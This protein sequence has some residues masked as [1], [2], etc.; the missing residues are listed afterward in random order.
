VIVPS[1][2][3]CSYDKAGRLLGLEIVHVDLDA[4]FRMDL[5]PVRAA[6]NDETIALVGVAGST[7]LGA[8]DPIEE[9]SDLALEHDLHLH[10]DAAFGG[11]VL[12]FLAELGLPPPAFDFRL[13][14]VSTITIDPH[15]MGMCVQPAGAV[16][17]RRPELRR[18]VAVDIPYLAGGHTVQTTLT[19]TRPG[20]AV[21]SVWAMLR[22]LGRTGYREVVRQCMGMTS[23]FAGRIRTLE[24]IELVV[25]PTL[26]IVGI[27]PTEVSVETLAARL[28]RRRW[29]LGQFSTHLRV[30]LL[31]HLRRSHVDRF[32]EDLVRLAR[33][34]AGDDAS[35]GRVG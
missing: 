16:L 8:V 29:A 17:Y 24:G 9:L 27:R 7:D 32:L 34:D 26:N 14:G 13:H 12:P 31:P 35:C 10:V 22:H 21:L 20:A 15:K 18:A 6:L 19:G 2:A 3:H 25:D 4:D 11:F 28:R 5:A 33:P 30:V 1:T 23:Y